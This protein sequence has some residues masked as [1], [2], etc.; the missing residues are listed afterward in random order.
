MSLTAL[1]LLLTASITHAWWNYAA[2]KT[3]GD[4]IFIWLVYC[5]SSVMLLPVILWSPSTRTVTC[6]IT[7]VTIVVTSAVL[8]LIYFLL[9]QKGYKVG[10]LSLVYPLARGT[11]PLF[12]TFG[13]ILIMHDKTTMYSWLGLSLIVVGVFLISGPHYYNRTPFLKSGLFT[14]LITGLII[15]VYTLWD[16]YAVSVYGLTPFMLIFASNAFSSIVLVP[17]GIIN[18]KVVG[19][20]VRNYK[21]QIALIGLLS[22]LSY[23][24]V[25]LAMRTT[26]LIYVAP[27]REVSILFAVFLGGRLLNEANVARR[28]IGCII[29]IAGIVALVL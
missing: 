24:L 15:A 1:A 3:K 14:G 26:P 21:G 4:L 5:C 16:Q 6:D 28:V 10:D 18:R 23:I 12:S 19:E 2:K 27:A 22:P 20:H 29:I 25:L 13:A 8:R 9:L 11:A 7:F 17:Y